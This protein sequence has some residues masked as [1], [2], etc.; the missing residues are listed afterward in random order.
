MA[1]LGSLNANAGAPAKFPWKDCGLMVMVVGSQAIGALAWSCLCGSR[2]LP[3]PHL[4][5]A[6]QPCHR[7]LCSCQTW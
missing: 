1:A 5:G 2:V 3:K 6:V 4:C 7:L